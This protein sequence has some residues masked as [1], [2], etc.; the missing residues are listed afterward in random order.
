MT[1]HETPGLTQ[2]DVLAVGDE[3]TADDVTDH[4]LIMIFLGGELETFPEHQISQK[5]TW[6]EGI[7]S[8]LAKETGKKLIH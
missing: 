7:S 8:Q 4:V 2:Y 6:L 1:N 3:T 5:N